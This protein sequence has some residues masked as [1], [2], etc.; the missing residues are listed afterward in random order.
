MM[1]EKAARALRPESGLAAFQGYRARAA[2]LLAASLLVSTEGQACSQDGE[3]CRASQCCAQEGSTCF[4]KND[5]WASCNATCAHNYKWENNQWNNKGDEHHWDCHALSCAE[6]GQN[7]MSSRCCAHYGSKCFQKDEHWASCNSTCSNNNLWEGG[8]WVD[9][10]CKQWDCDE[11]LPV[12]EVCDISECDGVG[13]YKARDQ[14]SEW[15]QRDC[16]LDEACRGAQGEQV[17]LCHSD[18]LNRCCEGR[19]GFCTTSLDI[20]DN[21]NPVDNNPGVMPAGPAKINVNIYYEVDCP[22]SKSFIA[23][24][25][26][27]LMANANCVQDYTTFNWVPYGNADVTD[28]GNPAGCQHGEDECYG[29]RLHLCAKRAFGADNAGLTAWIVCHMTNLMK[30]GAVA[31]Q[32]ANY[33]SCPGANAAELEQ[34]ATSEESLNMLKEAGSVTKVAAIQQA[35]WAVLE[36]I[37]SYNMQT[38]FM[39]DI[40]S[41][42]DTPPPDG[43]LGQIEKPFC[44][45][46]AAPFV[47]R[48]LLV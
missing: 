45:T 35:P 28:T 1:Q 39:V 2:V 20:D 26:G 9:K 24:E 21:S 48:R 23:N 7:C 10:G 34:C 19:S 5:H 44:C 13:G 40:C 30:E 47:G 42:F 14:C 36:T 22:F 33:A 6:D 18:N 4:R 12:A 41:V 25:V 17:A 32:Q 16:C 8:A 11:L 43:V 38:H 27:M 31:H 37:P 46:G 15:K 3:D 29:N